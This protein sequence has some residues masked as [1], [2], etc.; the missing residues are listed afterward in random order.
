MMAKI[1]SILLISF[2]LGQSY[3]VSD[4]GEDIRVEQATQVTLSGASSYPIDGSSIVEY[5]WSVI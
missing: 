5:V 1:F 4:P 2:M 3:P